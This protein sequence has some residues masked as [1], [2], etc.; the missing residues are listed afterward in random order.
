MIVPMLSHNAQLKDA[1]AA[2]LAEFI[3]SAGPLTS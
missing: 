3:Q 2:Y 1:R